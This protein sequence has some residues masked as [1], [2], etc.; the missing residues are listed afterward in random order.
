VLHRAVDGAA[1]LQAGERVAARGA[2]QPEQ[3][4]LRQQH[5]EAEV[6]Q[7]RAEEVQRHQPEAGGGRSVHLLRRLQRQ[8]LAHR[9]QQQQDHDEDARQ[10]Q[11]QPR[12]ATELVAHRHAHRGD[13]P[14]HHVSLSEIRQQNAP[15]RPCGPGAQHHDRAADQGQHDDL[16]DVGRRLAKKL[17]DTAAHDDEGQHQQQVGAVVGPPGARLAAQP[18]KEH[19]CREQQQEQPPMHDGALVFLEQQGASHPADGVEAKLKCN[20]PQQRADGGGVGTAH[21]RASVGTR[22]HPLMGNLPD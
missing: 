4:A 18:G 6:E 5:H 1:V 3:Q 11:R 19:A 17:L 14:C 16:L 7:R 10:H 9:Q 21:G 20:Q 12:R 15:G 13:Q 2:P 8:S 22:L